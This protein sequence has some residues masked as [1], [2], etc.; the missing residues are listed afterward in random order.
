MSSEDPQ[1]SNRQQGDEQ[2]L[3]RRRILQVLGTAVAAATL[4]A[5]LRDRSALAEPN[6]IDAGGQRP[7]ARREPHAVPR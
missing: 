2:G 1:E 4:E 7:R 6:Q 3:T 5:R